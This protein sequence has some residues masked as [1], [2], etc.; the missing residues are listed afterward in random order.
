[1]F[2]VVLLFGMARSVL[3]IFV[4]FCYVVLSFKNG[5]EAGTSVLLW[6][7]YS[8]HTLHGDSRLRNFQ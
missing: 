6:V 1:V 8:V 4:V 2:V 3:Q 7:S 5:G